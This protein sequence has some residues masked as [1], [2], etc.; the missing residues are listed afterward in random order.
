MTVHFAV[1]LVF[2]V[3]HYLALMGA[4]VCWCSDVAPVSIIE[5]CFQIGWF[6]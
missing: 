1:L 4:E 2:G 3:V 5:R 6:Y